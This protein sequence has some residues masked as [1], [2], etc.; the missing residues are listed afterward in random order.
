MG[1]G[2]QAQSCA[3]KMLRKM[4]MGIAAKEQRW[5]RASPKHY[6]RTHQHI[7]QFAAKIGC[8]SA[9]SSVAPTARKNRRSLGRRQREL[10]L[11]ARSLRARGDSGRVKVPELLTIPRAAQRAGLGVRQL[12]RATKVGELDVYQV[13]NWPRVRWRDVLGWIEAHQ[14]PPT[15]H[16][17]YRVAEILAR[18]SRDRKEG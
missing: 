9:T 18:E 10:R 14:V 15:S 5:D 2:T 4:G 8:N 1:R 11:K 3:D 17:K 16:A 6:L 12:R 7:R 13:G